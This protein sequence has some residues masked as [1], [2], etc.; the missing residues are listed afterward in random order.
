MVL[1]GEGEAVVVVVV[2]VVAVLLFV[3]AVLVLAGGA[4]EQAAVSSDATARAPSSTLIF[5][6]CS[7][8]LSMQ[9]SSVFNE[10]V[11]ILLPCTLSGTLTC[12]VLMTVGAPLVLTSATSRIRCEFVMPKNINKVN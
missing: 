5:I 11:S 8:F 9:W 4:D 3:V 7:G 10:L 2:V 1:A 6:Y 12:L